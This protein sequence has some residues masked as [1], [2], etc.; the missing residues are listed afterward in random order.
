MTREIA[1]DGLPVLTFE[2]SASWRE[3]L[4]QHF[5]AQAGVWLK[6]AR[7]ASGVATVTHDEALDEALCFGWIDGQ[8][9]KFDETYFIQRFTPR[10]ARSKWS[11]RNRDKVADLTQRGLMRPPGLAEV[12]RAKEDGRWAAAY[13]GPRTAT[14]PDD[15][16]KALDE[17]PAAR[18]L[19]D[20]LNSQNRYAILYRVADAR[21]PET[22]LERIERFVD[23]LAR[24]EK[25]HP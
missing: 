4:E 21:R 7:R 12:D 11:K 23:M 3:W 1:K 22:R 15:L 5:E 9:N 24:G 19:F 16:Q 25:P 18:A 13:D 10:R 14:V 17:N 2:D 8:R 6:I 20:T